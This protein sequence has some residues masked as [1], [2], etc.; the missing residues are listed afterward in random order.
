LFVN[1]CGVSVFNIVKSNS[2]STF[3]IPEYKKKPVATFSVF[4]RNSVTHDNCAIRRH[5]YIIK[6]HFMNSEGIT[7]KDI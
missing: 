2:E 7:N 3:C 5:L 6:C 4:P 1:G